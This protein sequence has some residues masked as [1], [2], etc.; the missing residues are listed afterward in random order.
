MSYMRIIIFFMTDPV[1]EKIQL[2]GSKAAKSFNSLFLELYNESIDENYFWQYCTLVTYE[3]HYQNRLN[4][5]LRNNPDADESDFIESEKVFFTEK[6]IKSQLEEALR[7]G[8]YFV[9]H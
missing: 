6:E 3:L 7:S 8:Q 5:F 9:S 1:L 2:L 4:D